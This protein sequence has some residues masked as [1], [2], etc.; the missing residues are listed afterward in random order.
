MRPLLWK[1]GLVSCL[2]PL[3][4]FK[5]YS[6]FKTLPCLQSRVLLEKHNP[7]RTNSRY[8]RMHTCNAIHN[9]TTALT[10][11]MRWIR[12]TAT[13]NNLKQ[14]TIKLICIHDCPRLHRY[15]ANKV[16]A[17][18]EPCRPQHEAS[19]A[20]VTFCRFTRLTHPSETIP[21]PPS[22]PQH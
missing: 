21:L 5:V 19:R 3:Y 1:K 17:L 14:L 7:I 11:L 6:S 9:K 4:T 16:R 22:F 2:R 8:S 12:E 18:P 20:S 10:I 15:R 13:K